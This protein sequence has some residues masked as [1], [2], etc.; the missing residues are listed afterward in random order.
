MDTL[1]RGLDK[2]GRIGGVEKRLSTLLYNY[3]RTP[4]TALGGKTPFELMTGRQ[5]PSRLDVLKKRSTSHQGLSAN[6][7]AMARQFDR[8]HGARGRSFEAGQAIWYQYHQGTTWSWQPAEVTQ[9]VGEAVYWIKVAGRT[10]KAHANQIKIRFDSAVLPLEPTDK[11]DYDSRWNP[12]AVPLSSRADGE[13]E[14]D[15]QV[16]DNGDAE[17]LDSSQYSD[18]AD[19][20]SAEPVAHTARPV[21]ATAGRPPAYL[22]DNY[23][24]ETFAEVLH[25]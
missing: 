3:R 17:D 6:Q 16:N 24:L 10:V 15:G 4:S 13:Q 9:R 14:D 23:I 18:A 19:M 22:S 25:S 2:L 7:E 8:H 21:R 5:M 11:S 20:P 1:K 12:P